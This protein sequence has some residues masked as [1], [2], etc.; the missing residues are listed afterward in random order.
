MNARFIKKKLMLYLA[1][2]GVINR[3]INLQCWNR[4]EI[5]LW[6]SRWFRWSKFI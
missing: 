2:D 4:K 3:E 1:W 5:K 6:I